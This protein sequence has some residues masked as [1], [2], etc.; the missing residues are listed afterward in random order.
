MRKIDDMKIVQG[1]GKTERA[2]CTTR[3]AAQLLGVSVSTAQVWVESGLLEAWKTEG[4]HRRIVRDSVMRLLANPRTHRAVVGSGLGHM[5]PDGAL[6]VLVV[7]D[8]NLL[9]RMYEIR[10]AAWACRPVVRTAENG[11]DALVRIGM[12]KPDLLIT[13][14][15]M[16]HMDGFEMLRNLV[17][18]S[19]F[20]AMKIIVVSGLDP[21]D[22][23]RAGGLPD[24]ILVFGKPIP[25]KELE[26]IAESILDS[27]DRFRMGGK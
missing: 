26:K 20:A 16:P 5:P 2:F 18:I 8:D 23:E 7:E 27:A 11:F 17:R 12:Q 25:F 15:S 1:T 19:E 24:S 3:E 4:G 14:L 10:L 22:I 9:R 13:D 21:E 6:K